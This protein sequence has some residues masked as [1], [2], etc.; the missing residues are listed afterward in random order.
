M[1]MDFTPVT[2]ST[3]RWT[4][5]TL[6]NHFI[7]EM[8]LD[9]NASGG[10]VPDRMKD[11]VRRCCA[12]LWDSYPWR[13]RLKRH[14]LTVWGTLTGTCTGVF[15]GTTTTITANTGTF[16]ESMVNHDLVV[17][18]VGAGT[19]EIQT[20]VDSTHI[21]VSGN[22]AAS[23]SAYT[24]TATGKYTF[25][26]WIA[27][28][29]QRW[30]TDRAKDSSRNLMVT[31]D[32]QRFQAVDDGYDS[33]DTGEPRMMLVARDFTET[34]FWWEGVVTPIPDDVYTFP[35]WALA[36][37]PFLS[38]SA[39]DNTVMPWPETFDEGWYRYARSKVQTAFGDNKEEADRAE[40]A[41]YKHWLPSQKA[42]NNATISN[43]EPISE[44]GYGDFSAL[45]SQRGVLWP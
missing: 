35:V 28:F 34:T 25:P 13:F 29:D 5:T 14:D 31:E 27:S 37:N 7:G 19:Y 6:A 26:A 40:A 30:L 17:T 11:L 33:D 41:Y 36:K 39:N 4:V 20:Y 10:T 23:A 15:G 8:N 18:G 38:E 45:A 1:S 2:A 3:T 44:D 43:P 16:Y 42:D 21:T 32:P 9:R 22:C 24:I 12:S